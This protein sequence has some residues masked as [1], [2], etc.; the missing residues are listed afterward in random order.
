MKDGMTAAALRSQYAAET[1]NGAGYIWGKRV[2]IL[3][4]GKAKKSGGN[5]AVLALLLA[6]AL[7]LV[8][9]VAFFLLISRD[10]GAEA[11]TAQS[12]AGKP[13]KK[14]NTAKEER[15]TRE[16]VID[17]NGEQVGYR[18]FE[19]NEAGQVI[20]EELFDMDDA[21][22]GCW[23]FTYSADGSE[24]ETCFYRYGEY[25]LRWVDYYDENGIRIEQRSYD[26]SDALTEIAYCDS[27]GNIVSR[28]LYQGA[29]GVEWKYSEEELNEQGMPTKSTFFDENGEADGVFSIEYDERGL[30]SR[31]VYYNA[32]GEFQWD[33]RMEY[34]ENGNCVCRREYY[35][36]EVLERYTTMEYNEDG[37]V[38]R[39][40]VY[41]AADELQNYTTTEFDSDGRPIAEHDYD[42]EGNMTSYAEYVYAEDGSY[43]CIYYRLDGTE[44]FRMSYDADGF[45]IG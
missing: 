4:A 43:D 22:Q 38:Q 23:E 37:K 30:E 19:Y 28:E 39:E 13:G 18:L 15:P 34:D 31:N 27:E 8:G 1:A 33:I 45:Y 32:D 44:R 7:V 20:K 6:L 35:E 21:A 29:P 2:Q 3:E 14:E 16:D 36:N 25:S 26:T 5:K 24:I 12:A 42:A 9:S 41:D 40:A 17:E 11:G 10:G